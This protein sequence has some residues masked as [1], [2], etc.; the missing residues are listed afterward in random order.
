MINFALTREVILMILPLILIQYGLSIYCVI[1]ILKKGTRNLNQVG[2]ILIVMF[3][4]LFG[5]IF[6]LSFGKR[7]DV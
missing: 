1:D 2:W 6:Y 4:N 5:A 3:V 7:K